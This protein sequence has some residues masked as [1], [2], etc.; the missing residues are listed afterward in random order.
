MAYCSKCGSQM[1]DNAAFCP[2]CGAAA[3]TGA[4]NPNG[5]PNP[6]GAPG[7]QPG[8]YA[9]YQTPP[10]S[11]PVYPNLAADAEA[12]KIF[13]ILAYL[14]VLVLVTIFAAPKTSIYARHHANQG[15]LLVLCVIALS[16]GLGILGALLGVIPF[17]PFGI[18]I[19]IYGLLW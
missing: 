12:N 1:T 13:G 11:D 18:R 6:G 8:Q 2:N 7:A 3:G 17:F 19:A 10:S 5:A 14:G 4:P 15:V 9:A 16:V